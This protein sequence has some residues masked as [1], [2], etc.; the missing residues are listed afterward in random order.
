MMVMFGASYKLVTSR[1]CLDWVSEW[2]NA[3]DICVVKMIIIFY[4]NVLLRTMKL[5][6]VAIVP[7]YQ[8]LGSVSWNP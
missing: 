3:L 6:V 1:I 4:F 2:Q 8:Y 7:N 5:V